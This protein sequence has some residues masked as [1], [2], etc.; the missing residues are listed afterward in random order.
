[1]G[2]SIS[3]ASIPRSDT[4]RRN[5]ISRL[6]NAQKEPTTAHLVQLP[7]LMPWRRN[8]LVLKPNRY[9]GQRRSLSPEAFSYAS[10][11]RRRGK[12]NAMTAATSIVTP[13]MPEGIAH[14]CR[15]V[16]EHTGQ[17][18]D[19]GSGPTTFTVPM[20]P[21]PVARMFV[22]VVL[23]CRG[24]DDRDDAR[25]RRDDRDKD[26]ADH[27]R[28]RRRV[29]QVE[30]VGQTEDAGERDHRSDDVFA[31]DMVG[32]RA[33]DKLADDGQDAAPGNGKRRGC[34]IKACRLDGCHVVLGR[35][36]VANLVNDVEDA[37]VQEIGILSTR[38]SASPAPTL[39]DF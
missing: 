39:P 14:N 12:V 19:R 29:R 3:L 9:G 4:P 30:E 7:A 28:G 36:H 1:M 31:L 13:T 24:H 10:F 25:R 22:G 35:C 6:A 37:E 2:F 15:C 26:P 27:K 20:K 16:D 21:V 17:A 33:Q 34:Q 38:L 5:E 32:E 18:T 23:A 11:L 8:R